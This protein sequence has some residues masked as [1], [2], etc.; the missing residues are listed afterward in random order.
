MSRRATVSA[1]SLGKPDCS[2]TAA[3]A[4]HDVADTALGEEIS[5]Q[6]IVSFSQSR[7]ATVATVAT[8]GFVSRSIF[9]VPSCDSCDSCD[10]SPSE[11]AFVATVATVAGV[12]SD[13]RLSKKLGNSALTFRP[14]EWF[15]RLRG[16]SALRP[17]PLRHEARASR[18][19]RAPLSPP[20]L[21]RYRG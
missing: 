7:P 16:R 17:Q 5:A 12:A 21:S 10:S 4:C 1:H 19:R 20:W 8:N 6:S 18:A 13:F 9:A 14:P 15:S 3:R 11:P 2:R